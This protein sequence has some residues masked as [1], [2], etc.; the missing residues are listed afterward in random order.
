MSWHP[1]G[2]LAINALRLAGFTIADGRRWA[3]S[4]YH[5]PLGLLGLTM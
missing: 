1:P 3:T 4:D 5:N 2:N